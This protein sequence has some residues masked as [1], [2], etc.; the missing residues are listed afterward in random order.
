MHKN[1]DI[2]YPLEYIHI[3]YQKLYQWGGAMV[4]WPL[5]HSL[6]GRK[7]HGKRSHHS[8]RLMCWPHAAGK[9]SPSDTRASFHM[10]VKA[11]KQVAMRTRHILEEG[12]G[13][14][15]WKGGMRR[16]GGDGQCGG[17]IRPGR[18]QDRLQW[19]RLNLVPFPK[20]VQPAWSNVDL[21]QWLNWCRSTLSFSSCLGIPPS[22]DT[23]IL[24]SHH[25]PILPYGI[26]WKM[27]CC[28]TLHRELGR[29]GL[30]RLAIVTSTESLQPI[31]MRPTHTETYRICCGTALNQCWWYVKKEITILKFQ[32]WDFQA[33]FQSLSNY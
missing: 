8:I 17:Q 4:L 26:Q 7:S 1:M 2:I 32:L 20:P 19:H 6:H 18:G 21:C 24:L 14:R 22:K 31:P 15:G 23:D 30:V 10:L 5:P 9:A 29:L 11:F 27:R 28:R 16:T 12:I 33:K 25:L 13:L 3:S